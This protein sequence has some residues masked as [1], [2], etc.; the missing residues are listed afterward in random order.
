MGTESIQNIGSTSI[1]QVNNSHAVIL[2]E[3]TQW[4]SKKE[5]FAGTAKINVDSISDNKGGRIK[6]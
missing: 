1:N 6:L 3:L 4:L 2:C 5:L